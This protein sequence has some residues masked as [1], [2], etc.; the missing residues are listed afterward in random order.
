MWESSPLL[1]ET[2]TNSLIWESNQNLLDCRLTQQ[3]KMFAIN[4]EFKSRSTFFNRSRIPLSKLR[5]WYESNALKLNQLNLFF[6]IYE[7]TPMKMSY[8]VL[9]RH[10]SKIGSGEAKFY[11]QIWQVLWTELEISI[12]F[13]GISAA[14]EKHVPKKFSILLN[15]RWHSRPFWANLALILLKFI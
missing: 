1:K 11:D 3:I 15:L 4:V 5:R 9:Q 2:A 7:D 12:V 10:W 6:F 14:K 13:E 8:L